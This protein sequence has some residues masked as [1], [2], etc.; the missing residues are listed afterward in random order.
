MSL[1]TF[2]LI[3][4]AASIALALGCGIWWIKGFFSSYNVR[5]LIYG[6]LSIAL[7]LAL[8][9]YERYFFKKLKSRRHLS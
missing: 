5:E 9:L 7:A 6:L 3:F 4:V 1:K 2:H 8:I